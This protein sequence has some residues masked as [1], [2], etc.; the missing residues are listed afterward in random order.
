MLVS[1]ALS[2]LGNPAKIVEAARAGRFVLVASPKLL[3]ELNDVLNRPK[4]ATRLDPEGLRR[5]REVLA[6][7]PVTGDPPAVAVSRD[8]KDDYLVALAQ[9]SEAECLVSGDKDLTVLGDLVPRVRTPAAFLE[10][11]STW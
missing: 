7:T 5:L 2:T 4:I 11:L 8:P 9:R 1:A 10:D 3:A 6:A